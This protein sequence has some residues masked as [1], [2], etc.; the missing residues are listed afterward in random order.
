M[1]THVQLVAVGTGG[2]GVDDSFE[3]QGDVLERVLSQKSGT[4]GLCPGSS[5]LGDLM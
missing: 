3:G 5:Q 4:L 1:C 2:S